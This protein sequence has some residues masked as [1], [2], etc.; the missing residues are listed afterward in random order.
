MD[1]N[2]VRSI[3]KSSLTD[4]LKEDLKNDLELDT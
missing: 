4:S 2:Q 1:T 3:G